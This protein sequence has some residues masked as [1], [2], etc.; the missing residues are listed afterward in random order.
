MFF[1]DTEIPQESII[2][3]FLLALLPGF[4]W[5]FFFFS[6]KNKPFWKNTIIMP[7]S[8]KVWLRVD[9]W[10]DYRNCKLSPVCIPYWWNLKLLLW[11]I[12]NSRKNEW[13]LENIYLWF[14]EVKSYCLM[15]N[16]KWRV[17][18]IWGSPLTKNW[19]C[20][21]DYM[22]GRVCSSYSVF[23][24]E[25]VEALFFTSFRKDQSIEI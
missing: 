17:S 13:K 5:L 4:F 18:N 12:Y 19:S 22:E 10:K 11:S 9:I 1:E 8:N 3:Y 7:L 20:E 6:Y 2:F 15:K 25:A 24:T 16:V 14:Q 21:D 23:L